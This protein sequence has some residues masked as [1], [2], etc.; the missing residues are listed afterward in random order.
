MLA[1]V[2]MTRLGIAGIGQFILVGVKAAFDSSS[3]LDITFA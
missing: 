3:C 2:S 1:Y